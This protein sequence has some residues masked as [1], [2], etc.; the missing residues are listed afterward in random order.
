VFAAAPN[1]SARSDEEEDEK[2]REEAGKV[3]SIFQGVSRLP[4]NTR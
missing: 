2:E 4:S 1:L 3:K